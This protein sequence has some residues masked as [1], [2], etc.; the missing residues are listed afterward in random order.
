IVTE[1][2]IEQAL[3]VQARTN[4]YLGQILI[5]LGYATAPVIGPVLAKTFRVPYVDLT[6]DQP[7]P[8]AVALVPERDI[9]SCHAV[10]LR[11]VGDTLHV[12]MLDPLDV[13]SIDRLHLITGRRIMP[14][15]S[16]GGELQR[17]V[18]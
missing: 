4:T 15:L 5:D 11:I 8:E 18:N 9:R 3:E 12:A 7:E 17:A 14:L 6:I 13:A 10:P 16:M 2:Q 1:E